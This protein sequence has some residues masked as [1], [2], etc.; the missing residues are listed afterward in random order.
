MRRMSHLI[1]IAL[2][3]AAPSALAAE[4]LE[5]KWPEHE[6]LRYFVSAQVKLPE[7]LPFI[8]EANVDA[9]VWLVRLDA[10]LTCRPEIRLGRKAT[11][12]RCDIDDVRLAAAPTRSDAGK[13]GPILDEY[14][15]K[16]LGAEVELNFRDD[17]RIRAVGLDGLELLNDRLVI[18]HESLRLML[19]RAVSSLDLELPR[20]GE[21][22]GES[23]RQRNP[24]APQFPVKHGTM[25]TATAEHVVSGTEGDVVTIETKGKG[26]LGSGEM[27]AVGN[28]EQPGNMYDMEMS[29]TAR[30]DTARGLMLERDVEV[31]GE[32]S[33][34][35]VA[36][37]NIGAQPY[38]HMGSVRLIESNTVPAPLPGNVELDWSTGAAPESP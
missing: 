21:D 9:R 28:Q 7:M 22:K 18:L 8:A 12:V 1:S 31:E 6:Q 16:L 20:K 23:W 29:A 32:P 2:L 27:I 15:E 24:L 38:V 37:D 5:W 30:F 13:L 4:G 17:G 14:D 26:L 34:S 36:I 35:T 3:A 11:E 10:V 19:V 33:T 25:G